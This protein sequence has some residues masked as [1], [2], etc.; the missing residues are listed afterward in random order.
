MKNMVTQLTVGKLRGL[1]AC[2]TPSGTLAILALDHRNNLR[3][4]LESSGAGSV[5]PQ[6][7]SEFKIEVSAA[8][9]PFASAVLLDPEFGVAQAI[10]SGRLPGSV[11]LLSAVEAT[12]YT[13]EPTGRE[14]NLLP[15]WSVA[16]AK[17]LGANAVKLLVYYH[18][19]S[20]TAKRNEALIEQVATDCRS[21][22]IPF[23]LEPLSFSLNPGQ[24]KLDPDERRTVVIETAKRLTQFGVDILKA[25]FPVDVEYMHSEQEW[26]EACKAL[27]AA[28][29]CPWV[30]LSAAV[31]FESFLRQLTIACQQGASGA[32]VGRAVW[33]EAVELQ[34]TERE[35]FLTQVAGPRMRQVATLCDELAQPWTATY[36]S[37]PADHNWYSSY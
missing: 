30:L 34:G 12:G 14:S 5:S 35:A 22:D 32:A 24:K 7:L 8:L 4:A 16:K 11:G 17:R 28:S 36:Q 23:M 9:A 1:Q 25:E 37:E 33:K 13:G 21:H 27:T 2:S 19:D 15:G 18:P 29:A 10:A 31:D 3:Q 20:D 26:A 6:V